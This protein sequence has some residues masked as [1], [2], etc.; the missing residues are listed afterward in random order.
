MVNEIANKQEAAA[1]QMMQTR[2]AGAAAPGHTLPIQM[3]Q[4]RVAGAAAP[5]CTD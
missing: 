4:T 2:V 3:M 5:G 1:Q